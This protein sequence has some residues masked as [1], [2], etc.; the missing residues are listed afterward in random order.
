MPPTVAL[1]IVAL[2]AGNIPP[3]FIPERPKTLGPLPSISVPK[4]ELEYA[5]SQE[6]ASLL[7][8]MAEVGATIMR[9]QLREVRQAVQSAAKRIEPDEDAGQDEG[10]DLPVAS[11]FARDTARDLAEKFVLATM[12]ESNG[13]MI[14]PRF[15]LAA[16]GG[17]SLH[18]KSPRVELLVSIPPERTDA[19]MF[20]GDTPGQSVRKGIFGRDESVRD[21]ALWLV[22]HELRR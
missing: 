10:D 21:V 3:P 4:M 13:S 1:R 7:Q 2:D 9:R 11:A 19:F 20:Y 8:H 18:W 15:E 16:D 17:T 5:Q 12:S 14:V 22:E 6:F